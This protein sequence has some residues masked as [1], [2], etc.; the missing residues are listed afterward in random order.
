MDVFLFLKG[1]AIGSY[2]VALR[3]FDSF[4]LPLDNGVRD[5]L[6]RVP[7][8]HAFHVKRVEHALSAFGALLFNLPHFLCFLL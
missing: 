7:S 3:L 6:I 2:E 8:L 4:E 5:I 1:V